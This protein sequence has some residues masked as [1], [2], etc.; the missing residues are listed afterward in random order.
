MYQT[1]K[2]A[3]LAKP[4][5]DVNDLCRIMTVLR[6]PEGCPWDRE[7]THKSVRNNLIE[8]TY[9]AVEAIDTE[10]SE[11]LCEE[12]GDLLMQVVFH[13]EMARE[14]GEFSFD[15]VAHR[16]SEKLVRRHP[17]VFGNE[18]AENSAEVL[19]KWD[20]VKSREKTERKTAS[21]KMRA[22][23]PCLPALLRAEK[24]IGR[25][26]KE[27]AYK[28]TPAA[29]AGAIAETAHALAAATDVE[30][31]AALSG[32]LAFLTA[33]L[34]RERETSSEETLSLH[35]AKCVDAFSI[36]ESENTQK[37]EKMPFFYDKI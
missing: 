19:V 36:W 3:L 8:E 34:S 15:D 23:P 9:E 22:I 25:A 2:N 37:N 29:L 12:L 13:S 21:D 27:T 32:R 11:L 26:E 35:L 33:A 18:S 10:N 6:S 7:Q 16:V 28:A 20:A 31:R 14:A 24:I 30:V 5:Y 4:H 17:H 1:E